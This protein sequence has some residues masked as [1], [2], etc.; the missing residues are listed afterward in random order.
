M[1]KISIKFKLRILFILLLLAISTIGYKS[2]SISQDNKDRLEV[3]H[4]KSQTLLG[5]QDKI[6]TPL[7]NLRELSQALVMAP[8]QKIRESILDNL[9][10]AIN[11]LDDAFLEYSK[12]NKIVYEMW[13]HYKSLIKVTKGYLNSEFEE[14]AYVNITTVGRAQF[15]LLVK[16][17]LVIQSDLLSKSS[18]AYSE[19]VK[20]VANIK[21]EIFVSLFVILLFSIIIGSLISNNIISSI[22]RVQNGLREFFEY[23]NHKRE[24]ANR[25]ELV[26]NDEFSDMANM[27]NE[28][29]ETI[30]NNIEKDEALIKNATRVLL[31]IKSGN[32]G[33][34][35]D[36]H[37]HNMALGELK[38]MIND[39]I[40]N[41]EEKIQ[42][43]INKRL[44]NEQILLQQSKLAS[45][46]E[47]IGNIAHQWR[48]PLAQIIAIFMNMKV[49]YDFDK[50]TPIYLNQKIEEAD[51]LTQ[52]M[53]QTIDDFQNFFNPHSVKE[54]FCV[55]RACRDA[56]FI[57][58][59]SLKHNHIKVEFEVLDELK[60]LGHKNEYSQV[61]LNII[62]N[63]KNILLEKKIKEPLI[64]IEIK[65][66]DNFAIVKIWDNGGGIPDE[67]LDKVFEPYFT[68][69][70]KTQGTGIGLYMSKNII[71]KNMQGYL[72]VKNIGDGACF[73]I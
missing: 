66:G 26:S 37:T 10:T 43:E 36:G 60:I 38:E 31:S 68:T 27:I 12:E 35:L 17:L 59:S 53:S 33:D 47:M 57:V 2:I 30:Q 19:A 20:D 32:L 5:L 8:N 13:L 71:E 7:Y 6:I 22:Y 58:E 49:T 34:R 16:E 41:L 14:G 15:Q 40:E 24:K 21:I 29:V 9:T 52:Y 64:K 42:Q 46:G 4:S 54:V 48:Q 51:K 70:H 25:I 45:M 63:A 56:L 3:V 50:F 11:E 65:E 69:R 67:F 1:N 73:T 39:M 62:N 55:E 61:V 72:N 44:E 23:I 28:N 18:I